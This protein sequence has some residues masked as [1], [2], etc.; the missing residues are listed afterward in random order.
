MRKYQ[1]YVVLKSMQYCV[2][3]CA[4]IKI[5]KNK[6]IRVRLLIIHFECDF[7]NFMHYFYRFYNSFL[8]VTFNKV[9]F[10]S[11]YV[12]SFHFSYKEK[13]SSPLYLDFFKKTKK[14]LYPT[15]LQRWKKTYLNCS[16]W[17]TNMKNYFQ[18]NFSFP[19]IFF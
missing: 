13:L 18:N 16:T 1:N 3:K 15:F 12:N 9:N 17:Y 11:T 2:R 7:T 5:K 19:F 10:M 8:D 6:K 4:A 14:T